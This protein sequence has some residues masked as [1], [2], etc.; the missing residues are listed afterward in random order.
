MLKTIPLIFALL[1]LTACSSTPTTPPPVN[2]VLQGKTKASIQFQNTPAVTGVRFNT[3]GFTIFGAI[4]VAAA[5]AQMNENSANMQAAYEQYFK[6]HPDAMS[7]EKTFNTE[8]K[9]RLEDSGIALTE[10]SAEKKITDNK[11]S[12]TVN[13]SEVNDSQAI[14]IDGLLAQFFAVSS[15]DD[16]NPKAGILVTVMDGTVAS[17]TPLQQQEFAVIRPEAYKNYEEVSADPKKSYL[18]LQ[19]SVKELAAQV[20]DALLG[21]TSV[22]P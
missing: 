12:Y 18:I 7:L 17:D 1:F 16:Y 8:L 20:A 5:V 14:V 21:K 22:T 9:K 13:P 2:G 19:Q 6:D 11:V 4:Y 3:Q 10:I 15:T